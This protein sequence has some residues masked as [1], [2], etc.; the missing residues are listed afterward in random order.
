MDH[1]YVLTSTMGFEAVLA[2][3]PVTCFGRPW[4][5]GL[6]ATDDRQI[7]NRRAA[8]RSIDELFAAAYFHYTRYIDPVTHQRGTIFNV[9]TWLVHQKEMTARLMNRAGASRMIGIGFRRWKD[10]KSTRL[11]SSH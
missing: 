2:G 4:Y 8:T 6:G 3:K 11:N 1:V 5:A 10:R 9:V 7:C